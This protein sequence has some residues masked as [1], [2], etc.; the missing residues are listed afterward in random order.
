[1]NGVFIKKFQGTNYFYDRVFIDSIILKNLSSEGFPIFQWDTERPYSSGEKLGAA[2]V[3]DFAIRIYLN[4]PEI[5]QAGKTVKEFFVPVDD[6]EEYFYLVIVIWGEHEY[7][8]IARQNNISGYFTYS[9]GDLHLDL[10]AFGVLKDFS[11]RVKRAALGTLDFRDGQIKTFEDYILFH[12]SGLTSGVV[13][14]SLPQTSYLSKL[15]GNPAGCWAY[16]DFFNFIENKMNISRWEAFSELS[17]GIG[18]NFKMSLNPGTEVSSEPEFIFE[19]F[20]LDDL[21]NT[22]PLRIDQVM[23]HEQTFQRPAGKWLYLQYRFFNLAPLV[24]GEDT[25]ANGIISSLD[26]SYDADADNGH[27]ALFPAF[28]PTISGNLL[29]Y[30]EGNSALLQVY[31]ETEFHEYALKQYPYNVHSGQPIGKLMPPTEERVTSV[32]MAY[33][34]IFNAATGVGTNIDR[35]NH[36]PIQRYA[37]KNYKRYIKGWVREKQIQVAL[38]PKVPYKLWQSVVIDEGAGDILYFIN[39]IRDVDFVNYTCELRLSKL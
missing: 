19:I 39:A 29:N 2:T 32:G 36:K 11:D 20:F 34:K 3:G 38:N 5:S 12:F 16:G 4:M 10:W 18:F 24:G 23:K 17:R 15:P 25:Y 21:A 1:M 26:N 37:I 9:K 30:D 13:N 28:I 22:E 7:S 27:D 31:R 6:F 35:Y 33:A 14:I 8:G